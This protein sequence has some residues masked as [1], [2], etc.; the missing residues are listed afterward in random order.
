M[1]L[2]RLRPRTARVVRAS[3]AALAVAL[4]CVP[5]FADVSHYG[6]YVQ[7]VHSPGAGGGCLYFTLVGVIEAD[8][9]VAGNS[10]FAIPLTH[11]G[12]KE[13]FML[14]TTAKVSERTVSMRTSTSTACGYAAAEY[15]YMN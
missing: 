1:G 15:V 13:I 3:L 6:K 5:A 2:K 10:W 4:L 11:P 7:Y 9:I 8:P 12:A 14:L